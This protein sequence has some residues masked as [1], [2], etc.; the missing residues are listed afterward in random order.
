[1]KP[2]VAIPI[3][4]HG[5]TIKNVVDALAHL[6]LPCVIV[7]DGS[8]QPTRSV[9]SR[10]ARR[11]SFV[12]L[13]RH[14]QNR[15][16]GAALKTAYGWAGAQE[17]THIVQVDADGQHRVEDIPKFLDAAALQPDALILGDPV[18][19]ES[20][21]RIR[22][23]GRQ[24][25]RAIVWIE[26]LSTSVSDPLCGFRCIPLAPT[27]KTL[28]RFEMGDYMDFDPEL[29]IRLV[30]ASVP[31]VNLPTQVQY[32]EDG[33]SHFHM[34]KDNLRLAS[35]YIR[36]ALEFPRGRSSNAY[37]TESAP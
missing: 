15:G 14:A 13:L 35:A 23:Y 28:S 30:R 26:T 5:E 16:R 7:D 2:C 24:L 4:D 21:P 31:V 12:T 8:S 11:H 33:L 1:L 36:L 37:S 18:F 34:V 10:L 9:L 3:Y 20:A 25:S 29:A 22:L 17:M 6:G 19:D 27:L 32:P